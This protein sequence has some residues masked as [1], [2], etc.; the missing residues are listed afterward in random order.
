MIPDGR[1]LWTNQTASHSLTKAWQ[2]AV[3]WSPCLL[4]L[5][6]PETHLPLICGLIALIGLSINDK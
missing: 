6:S 3:K 1:G 5:H 4:F 2:I